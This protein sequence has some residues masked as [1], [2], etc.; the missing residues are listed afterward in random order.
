M[1]VICRTKY[2]DSKI[3]LADNPN[4]AYIRLKTLIIP[5]IFSRFCT[6]F[7]E[8]L[9]GMLEKTNIKFLPVEKLM[10]EADSQ[11]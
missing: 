1:F 2:N 5:R 7:D 8:S 10:G 11:N 6:R 4:E 3:E 9:E